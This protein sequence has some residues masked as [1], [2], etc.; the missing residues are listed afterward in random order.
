MRCCCNPAKV[1]GTVE[2]R[3]P[4]L[5]EQVWVI[6]VC[7]SVDFSMTSP[8]DVQVA[9]HV[10]RLP[11]G[12]VMLQDGQMVEALKSMDTPIEELRK[13]PSFREA[14]RFSPSSPARTEG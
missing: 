1:L 12:R 3:N 4:H 13:I 11:L 5:S 9:R 14:G 2:V 10:I 8:S 6:P 7:R